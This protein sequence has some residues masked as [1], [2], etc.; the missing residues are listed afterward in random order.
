MVRK[1]LIDTSVLIALHKVDLIEKLSILW[2]EI[3]I[4]IGVKAE[5]T[6]KGKALIMRK[7]LRKF[8]VLCKV[9]DEFSVEWLIKE[10]LGHGEAE[11]IAQAKETGVKEVIIDEIRARKYAGYHGLKVIGSIGILR[12]L[13]KVGIISDVS[14]IVDKLRKGGVRLPPNWKV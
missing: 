13:E 6:R 7:L 4:P 5:F 11:V 8:F 9:S 1:A 12:E 3:K 14:M 10:G 2:T